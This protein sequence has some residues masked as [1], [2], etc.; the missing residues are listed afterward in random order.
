MMD[1]LNPMAN[2]TYN[3]NSTTLWS[4]LNSIHDGVILTDSKGKVEFI[5]GVASQLMGRESRSA[6]GANIRDIFTLLR[7]TD[8]KALKF[9]LK[10]A[11]AQPK[12]KSSGRQS[13]LKSISGEEYLI[14]RST[15]E[16][17]DNATGTVCGYVTIFKDMTEKERRRQ[18][19]HH[20]E[21]VEA[22]SIMARSVAHDFNNILGIIHG[23]ANTITENLLPNS[24]SHDA[25]TMIMEA[26]DHGGNLTRRLLSVARA[27]SVDN[28][29][30]LM[31]VLLQD[32]VQHAISLLE[33]Q[34]QDMGVEL[35]IKLPDEP[36]FVTANDSQLLDT[37][38][39]ILFNALE[40]TPESGTVTIDCTE[41]MISNPNTTLN[42]KALPGPYIILRVRDTGHG[43]RKEDITRLFEP[44]FTTYPGTAIG[45]GLTV[46]QSNVHRW[47]GWIRVRSRPEHGASFRLFVPKSTQRIVQTDD[48]SLFKPSMR[49]ILLVESDKVEAS[50]LH[51]LLTEVGYS[52]QT[53][54]TEDDGLAL[55]HSLENKPDMIIMEFNVLHDGPGLIKAAVDEEKDVDILIMTGFSR[56]FLRSRVPR[57]K[58]GYLQKPLSDQHFLQLVRKRFTPDTRIRKKSIR[59]DQS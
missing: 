48:T 19:N 47:G 23:Y 59:P 56:E 54:A 18:R 50:R 34:F 5:N 17:L 53:V 11:V 41:E 30:R 9:D 7:P 31:P 28:D 8:R 13:I 10:H 32:T 51:H 40:A 24:A 35:K 14:D 36:L 37:L 3:P 46:A 20:A 33:G 29:A 6:V 38:M 1:T 58:W 21:K 39:N 44:F 43:I 45:L 42:P 55:F 57:G 26:A 16:I 4:V 52:V 25:A 2:S 12:T 15:T 27:G 49:T 22:I